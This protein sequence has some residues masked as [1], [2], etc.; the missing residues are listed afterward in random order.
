V[1][2][3]DWSTAE[4]AIVARI[5]AVLSDIDVVWAHQT[6]PFAVPPPVVVLA[7]ASMRPVDSEDFRQEYDE[8]ADHDEEITETTRLFWDCTASVEIR[9]TNANTTGDSSPH[10]LACSLLTSLRTEA[11]HSALGTAVLGLISNGEIALEPE[12]FKNTWQPRATFPIRFYAVTEATE[13]LGYI[14]TVRLTTTAPLPVETL[15]D[16]DVSGE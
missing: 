14:A 4:N 13:A 7:F 5:K 9:T 2:G 3:T 1:A 8:D 10:A 16:M 15:P 12:L 11:N 6:N